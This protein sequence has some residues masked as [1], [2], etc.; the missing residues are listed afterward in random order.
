MYQNISPQD[1]SISLLT[2]LGSYRFMKDTNKN[3]LILYQNRVST[4]IELNREKIVGVE[5]ETDNSIFAIEGINYILEIIISDEWVGYELSIMSD[6]KDYFRCDY[7]MEND[8][9]FDPYSVTLDI[10]DE[11]IELLHSLFKSKIRFQASSVKTIIVV[12]RPDK[13][14]DIVCNQKK[15]FLWIKHSYSWFKNVKSKEDLNELIIGPLKVLE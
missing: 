14:F 11:I 9:I 6:T 13:S 3:D 2:R 4:L 1:T 12:E 15:K 5:K 10:Y 7:A 8:G